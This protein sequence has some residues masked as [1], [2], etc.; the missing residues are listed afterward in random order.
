MVIH[1]LSSEAVAEGFAQYL[2][3]TP[4]IAISK[5]Y[6]VIASENYKMIQLH[7]NLEAYIAE[8]TN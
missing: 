4:D 1:Y 5:P 3:A 7:K 6:T 8:Q 2:R